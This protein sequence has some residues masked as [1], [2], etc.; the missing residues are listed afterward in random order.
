[1]RCLVHDLPYGDTIMSTLELSQSTVNVRKAAFPDLP[2]AFPRTM[3][4]NAMKYLA[5]VVDS[6]LS[7]NMITRFENAFAKELGVTH[8]IATPGCTPALAVLAAALPFS[9]GD[10]I[11][12]SSVTD[13]GTVQGLIREGYIPIFADTEPGTVNISA[14][15]IEKAVSSRTR[16]VLVVHKTGII[17]DMDAISALTKKHGLFL[18]EDCCQAVFGVYKGRFAG[19]L[20]DAAAFSFDS[21][22]T[23]GSDTGGCIVTNDN[24]LAE[25]MRFIGQLRGSTMDPPFGRKHTALG[26]AFRM[27]LCTAAVTLAQLEIIREQVLH[28]DKMIRLLIG[29]LEDVPGIKPLVIPDYLDVYSCWMVGFSIDPEEFRC[30]AVEFGKQVATGG[31]PGAGT[32][33][34]YLMPE[35]L[36]FLQKNAENHMFPFA[37]PY[38]SRDYV[39]D[40]QSCPNAHKFLKTWIRWSTFS[41]KYEPVHC[42]AAADIIAKT[43]DSNRC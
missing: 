16:A 39:Y 30:D 37:Q 31:I 38:A 28:R 21:E 41:E 26:Y 24:V 1:M 14:A 6:G 42:E 5:E 32:A 43:A 36:T 18:Y 10:E 19:T 34:Y 4:P 35:A 22:K 25:R 2:S 8:C 15:T 12:V 9:P 11:I 23:M 20:A 17:C 7:C 3:G 33:Q 27:P 13:Y 40:E 29:L